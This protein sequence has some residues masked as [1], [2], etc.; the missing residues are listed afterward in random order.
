M[1]RALF[2]SDIHIS[3]ATDPKA[4]LF[5]R[6]LSA[7]LRAKVTDLFLVGDIFDL[8]VA[9]RATFVY[10]YNEIVVKIRQV[11]TMGGRVY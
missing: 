10:E 1:S 3:S 6:F 9:D 7:C 11:I 8:W 4:G 5:L 2:V